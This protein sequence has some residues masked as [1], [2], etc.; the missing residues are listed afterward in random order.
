MHAYIPYI[1]TYMHTYIPYICIQT[2]EH[3]YTP[4]RNMKD[5]S[6]VGIV[7]GAVNRINNFPAVSTDSDETEDDIKTTL[8]SINSFNIILRLI[9]I[10]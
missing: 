1:N 7:A 8:K 6:P 3:T 4:A 5:F 2:C 9:R 10:N